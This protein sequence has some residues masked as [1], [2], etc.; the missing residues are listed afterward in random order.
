MLGSRLVGVYA[1][2][3]V[4]LGAY[5]HGRSDVDVAAVAEGQV[6]RPERESLGAAL[7]HEGLPCPARGLEFVLYPLET[8]RGGGADPGFLLN[9]NSGPRMAFRLDL[10]PGPEDSHW[11]AID[12][13]ILAQHGV[14]LAGPPAGEVFGPVAQGVLLPLLARSIEW[15]L[16]GIGRGD[17][18]V[19]NAARALRYLTEQRWSSK[20]E[21]GVWALTRVADPSLVRRALRARQGGRDVPW[22]EAA[23]FVAEVRRQVEQ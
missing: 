9:L 22:D 17:D 13:S 11:F 20:A 18:A 16:Q 3:S 2:G 10:E 15:H 5:Q 1:G 4:A 8:A 14:T 6:S 21:A 19:L 12:R 7:R 23:A